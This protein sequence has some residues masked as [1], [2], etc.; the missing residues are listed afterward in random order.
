VLDSTVELDSVPEFV[1]LASTPISQVFLSAISLRMEESTEQSAGFAKVMALVNDLIHD[2]RKQ[3]QSIRRIN[4]RVKGQCLI[5]NNRLVN[6][7][8]SFTNM[9]RY[10]KSRAS[11]ALSEKSEAVNMRNSRRNQAKDY[12]AAQARFNLAF[13]NKSAKWDKRIKAR[14]SALTYVVAAIKVV[15]DWKP[16]NSS[17]FIQEKISKSVEE[18]QKVMKF[19]LD[20]DHEMVQLAA[21]DEKIKRRLF[22]W[23]NMLKASIIAA[24]DLAQ[25]S[26]KHVTNSH[27][28][29]DKLLS[30][31]IKLENADVVRLKKSI[32]NWT[33]L[34][35]NYN[36]NEKI[37][38]ALNLQT[39]NVLKANKEW[40][41]VESANYDKSRQAMSDQL[42]VF[43][44][45]KLW[46]RKN[47]SRV[48]QW[49]RKRYNH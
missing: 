16:N 38:S 3:L 42:K 47:Y 4:E 9:L 36:D 41:K 21:S 5:A 35:K 24:I 7:Q 28:N 46:L 45:L 29:L 40:C 2:N 27:D 1:Q 33:I 31:I 15:T 8:R 48:R 32:N 10:Y 23:L 12:A 13:K 19:P 26:K 20:Y 11:L 14:Q 22:Q 30:Q 6:R 44:E 43:V 18:Y 39:Q 37:Y 34:L 25:S 49:L 17:A